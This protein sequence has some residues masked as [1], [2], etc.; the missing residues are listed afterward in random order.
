MGAAMLGHPL[1]A[2]FGDT[3]PLEEQVR[4]MQRRIEE[5]RAQ[6]VQEME[7]QRRRA[8]SEMISRTSTGNWSWF[9]KVGKFGGDIELN[10][11]ITLQGEGVAQHP[12]GGGTAQLGD[13]SRR[14]LRR[15]LAAQRYEIARDNQ[16]GMEFKRGSGWGKVFSNDIRDFS[17]TL[18]CRIERRGADGLNIALTG[19]VSAKG[20]T[21]G[22]PQRL[23]D[24]LDD[25]LEAF[26]YEQF[27]LDIP[28]AG[29]PIPEPGAHR[30]APSRSQ[31]NPQPAQHPPGTLGVTLGGGWSMPE[32]ST[33]GGYKDNAVL[34]A[35][36]TI[37]RPSLS[38]DD[39]PL[40]LQMCKDVLTRQ[41]YQ[42]AAA[43]AARLEA[44]RGTS[45]SKLYATGIAS[46]QT[47][48]KLTLQTLPAENL[49]TIELEGEA[50]VGGQVFSN[51]GLLNKEL[52]ELADTLRTTIRG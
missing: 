41:K 44:W 38:A 43:S 47:T 9:M 26:L 12:D 46:A 21:A 15:A 25:L 20:Y 39:L 31:A 10:A 11:A 7:A 16:D 4:A 36:I 23:N 3:R 13:Q 8:G 45:L 33:L 42:I 35:R 37:H 30:A 34:A 22:N 6:A 52:E 14:V 50:Q 29:A 1:P 2:D 40:A 27:E 48:L 18:Q 24:E 49:L 19:A 17:T 5:L 28:R 32:K 51:A